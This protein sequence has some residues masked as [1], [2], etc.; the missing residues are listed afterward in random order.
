ME[1]INV[2]IKQKTRDIKNFMI[3]TKQST[4]I[5]KKAEDIAEKYFNNKTRK[6]Y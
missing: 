1:S 4:L 5:D 3:V 6:N 2:K